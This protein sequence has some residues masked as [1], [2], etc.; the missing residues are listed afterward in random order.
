[1][2]AA[3][4]LS[5][6][7]GTPLHPR[8]DN[9]RFGGTIGGPIIRNKLF[10]FADYEYNPVGQAGS[11]GLLYAPTAAGYSTLGGLPGISASN[12]SQLQKYLPAAS[13]S[14][15]GTV[16]IGNGNESACTGVWAVSACSPGSGITGAAPAGVTSIPI[17]QVSIGTPNY[18]NYESGV[19]SIDYNISN[20]DSLRGRFI[21]NRTGFIDTSASLPTFFTTVPSNYYLATIS[22][23]HNFSPSLTNELRIGFNRYSQVY[24]A[25]NFSWPGLDM[26]PN[27][28]VFELN[29]QLGPDPN[30][31]QFGYQNT[32]QLTDNISWVHGAH[33]LKFGFD[34]IRWINPQSFTQ[35]VRGDYEWSFLSDYL[36]DNIPDY[37]GERS[38]GNPIYWGNRTMIGFYG[39]DAWKL[40]PNL[41]I[42]LGLRWE[43]ESN[44]AAADQQTL[45]AP[46]S[47]P[48]LIT[49]GNPTTQFKNFMPR[50]GIAWSPGNSGK[51]SVRAGFGINYD[52]LYDNLGLLSLPPRVVTRRVDVGG[53]LGTRI[54]WRA[55]AFCPVHPPRSISPADARAETAAY[56]PN[57]K[58]PESLQWNFGIQHTFGNNYL[59]EVHY[60][61]DRG[62][63]LPVQD[64][65]EPPAVVTPTNSLP[66]YWSAPDPGHPRCA[67]HSRPRN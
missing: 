30:A 12:L 9:N 36:Y 49:F 18:A 22:E 47:V 16:L 19:A 63:F 8:Y 45:N 7:D 44:P 11:A 2:D 61:G 13:G 65:P 67:D 24:G 52:V 32:Y 27:I 59:L 39:N 66:L 28:D 21:L 57:Q 58:R 54:S 37:L 48:G 41:T 42:N 29:V 43:W 14:S 20:D 34:G 10:F 15:T 26:F 46:A 40:R 6:V 35:R 60:L 1:M 55:A 4:N 31:P 51:T 3:D 17:G 64:P 56:I 53:N 23:Y 33:S 62:L 50:I 25:G 38:S 5:A